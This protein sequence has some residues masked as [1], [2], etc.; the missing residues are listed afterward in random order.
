MSE[1]ANEG[2]I[3]RTAMVHAGHSLVEGIYLGRCYY[4]LGLLQC[5]HAYS[6]HCAPSN[7]HWL[8][9]A[10]SSAWAGMADDCK[11]TYAT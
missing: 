10:S 1:A 4:G 8:D 6:M 9:G 3:I 7:M 2:D 5:L 11:L